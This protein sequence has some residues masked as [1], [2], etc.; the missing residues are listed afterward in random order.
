[1]RC[2][3]CGAPLRLAEEPPPRPLDR[4]LDLD[5]RLREQ[6]PA[7]PRAAESHWDLGRPVAAARTEPVRS[8][9]GPARPDAPRPRQPAAAPATGPA[10]RPLPPGA[11]VTPAGAYPDVDVSTIEIHLRRGPTWRRLASWAV[12]AALL[13][14]V[15]A[16]VVWLVVAAAGPAATVAQTDIDSLVALAVRLERFLVPTLI[17]AALAAAVY[18][19]LSVALMGATP[20]KMLLRLKVVGRDGRQP[21]PRRAAARAAL[22]VLS[23]ALLG[24]G[25]L[26]ALFSRSGRALHDFLCGTYV[27]ER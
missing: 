27:V 21:S 15:V 8:R 22:S 26:L 5:R 23:V 9:P 12:D 20:G 16:P 2:A 3:R 19:G 7:R 25:C 13:G 1:M 24:L 11:E 10:A 17:F 4:T 14:L 6:P 18:S